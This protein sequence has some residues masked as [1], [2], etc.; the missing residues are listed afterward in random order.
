MGN[1]ETWHKAL[2]T[3]DLLKFVQM[4]IL[5]FTKDPELFYQKY[6]S[7]QDFMDLEMAFIKW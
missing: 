5:G 3:R 2:G 7:L 6:H 4:M 1:L